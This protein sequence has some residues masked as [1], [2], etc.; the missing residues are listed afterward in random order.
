MGISRSENMSRIRSRDTAPEV[1]LRK[2]LWRQGLRYR[3]GYDLPGR[4]DL[5]F[6]GPRVTV[7]VDGCFWHGC[8]VHY[9]AP[10]TRH[11]FW[12][13]KLRDNVERDLAVDDTLTKLGWR[14]FHVWQH[15]LK[16]LRQLVWRIA[17]CLQEGPSARGEN[18]A[19]N[20]DGPRVDFVAEP[21]AVY[22]AVDSPWYQCRC[23]SN[24]VRVLAVRGPGSLRPSAER[25]PRAAE[26]VCV[27]CREVFERHPRPVA[28]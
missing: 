20:G 10:T 1:K 24:D 17:L 11:E 25:Q 8:P 23:G 16:D 3:L 27:R 13:R 9:S 22:Q 26:L 4:P 28:L 12:A 21:Q 6:I 14:P 2:A 5:T 18:D 19:G 7:F 15:E